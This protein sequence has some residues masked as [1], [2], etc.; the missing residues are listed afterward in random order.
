MNTSLFKVITL[1]FIAA[2]LYPGEVQ[3]QPLGNGMDGAQS[4]AGVVNK[5]AQVK[6]I[7]NG[8]SNATSFTVDTGSFFAVNDLVLVIQM[9]GAT[10][11]NSNTSTYGAVSNIGNCGNY[12][13]VVVTNVSGN[14]IVTHKIQKTYTSGAAAGVQLVKVPQYTSATITGT[15]SGMP[16]NGSKGGIIAIDASSIIF[17]ANV[18]ANFLGFRPG[19]V[20][21]DLTDPSDIT[22]YYGDFDSL[23]GMKGEGIAG[24]GDVSGINVYGRGAAANGGGG[25]DNHNAGGGGGSN[26]GCGGIGG[27]G[28][29]SYIQYSSQ[30]IGG[31]SLL[32]EIN[33]NKV[34][35]GG[36]GGTG[37][38]NDNTTMPAGS[39]GGI[40]ILTTNSLAGN[41]N[42]IICNGQDGQAAGIDGA[43]GG[44]AG[45]SVLLYTDSYNNIVV[46]CNGGNG[47]GAAVFNG[48]HLQ[49]P[50]GG[51]GG[52]YVW[53]KTYDDTKI[54]YAADSGLAGICDTS[55]FGATAGCKGNVLTNLTIPSKVGN[56]NSN[57]GELNVKTYPNPTKNLIHLSMPETSSFENEILVYDVM[58]NTIYSQSTTGEELDIACANWSSGIYFI[59]VS[60]EKDYS[61]VRLVKE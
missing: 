58:G 46:H 8:N 2:L 3:S 37:Q 25:G 51:G 11:D 26:A 7:N 15:L 28:Y 34:F 59:K 55:A 47:G 10:I 32:T 29:Y 45:G 50:G 39:G 17:Q 53:V 33:Q 52:G 16:W 22:S 31:Y 19:A 41:G 14:I 12:E 27:Y 30:G 9:Q 38:E 36:A 48:V 54:N 60:N 44:G 43:S 6:S 23:M 20:K 42:S 61:V 18:N 13:Y 40:V 5:Y 24:Y 49:A 1:S 35:M 21:N 4:I 57:R 56:L